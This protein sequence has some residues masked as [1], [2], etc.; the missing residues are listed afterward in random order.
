MAKSLVKPMSMISEVVTAVATA[1]TAVILWK[2]WS[3]SK[4]SLRLS[5]TAIP[6]NSTG[7]LLE[8]DVA[9]SVNVTNLSS[10]PN[11]IISGQVTY[12][13]PEGKRAVAGTIVCTTPFPINIPPQQTITIEFSGTMVGVGDVPC[14]LTASLR[15]QYERAH[16]VKITAP[17]SEG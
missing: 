12:F 8:W 13:D 16:E 2:Q 6:L 4:P 17:K 7:T 5:G 9:G 15:D 14:E 3:A 1:V 10:T 11:A